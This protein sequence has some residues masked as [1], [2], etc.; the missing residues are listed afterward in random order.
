MDLKYRVLISDR[1]FKAIAY[2]EN[3]ISSL[4]FE[5]SATGG[6]GSFRFSLPKQYENSRF[7]LG[8]YNIKI[9][10][11]NESSGDF[12][13]KYQGYIQRVKRS[14]SGI[15]DTFSVNGLGYIGKLSKININSTFTSQEAS[16]SVKD[17]LD[18][19]V[20]P[21]TDI[22]YSEGDIDNTGFTPD[23]IKFNYE[24]SD[25]AIQKI[26]DIVGSREWGVDKNRKLY[27]KARNTTI[28]KEFVLGKNITDFE[29][30]HDYETIINRVIIQGGTLADD[31]TYIKIYDEVKSQYKYGRKDKLIQNS[32]IT[33]D[34]VAAQFKDSVFANKKYGTRKSSCRLCN[35]Y[36]FLEDAIPLPIFVYREVGETF[37]TRKFGSGR[38][39][40]LLKQRI[41]RIKYNINNKGAFTVA[42]DL[43]DIAPAITEDL[44]KLEY[45]LEQQRSASI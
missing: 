25:S 45:Q 33:T 21:N 1:A 37:G 24:S 30:E 15:K 40:G 2:I 22:S 28:K 14:F 41:K 29:L 23:T 31:S 34:T 20:V 4:S 26:A 35:F 36:E 10:I 9:Y 19:D 7:L 42:L 27:F 6:C 13:L 32:S 12:E 11:L 17:I 39:N 44:S 43:D 3:G 18:N 5:H 16:Q 8:G 38:Y